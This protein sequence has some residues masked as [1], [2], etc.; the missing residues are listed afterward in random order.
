MPRYLAIQGG[1][2]VLFGLLF[3]LG[4]WIGDIGG[5][6]TL[7]ARSN[8]PVIPLVFVSGSVV[9]ILPLVLA[10]GV[11]LIP[12]GDASSGHAARIEKGVDAK[13]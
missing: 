5:I 12:Q 11:A 4:V 7:I 8:D 1:I 6:G 10:T 13:H 9:A 2:G 3:A